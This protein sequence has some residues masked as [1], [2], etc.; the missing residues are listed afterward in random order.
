[1]ACPENINQFFV[2]PCELVHIASN[3][4]PSSLRGDDRT[5]H[6]RIL[7]LILGGRVVL[8]GCHRGVDYGSAADRGEPPRPAGAAQGGVAGRVGA[9][10]APSGPRQGRDGVPT[11][12]VSSARLKATGPKTARARVGKAHVSFG[13]EV[14][15]ANADGDHSHIAAILP[16]VAG[17]THNACTAGPW[18][19]APCRKPRGPLW[20]ASDPRRAIPVHPFGSNAD[21]HAVG[22]RPRT[23]V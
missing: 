18:R 22:A 23:A 7:G 5:R 20:R 21:I 14:G 3:P 17:K 9:D 15:W 6:L 10:A 19:Q 4:P 16:R 12:R 11:A 8:L 1:M 13:D 2:A